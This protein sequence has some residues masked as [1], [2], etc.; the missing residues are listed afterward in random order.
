MQEKHKEMG[1]E[2]IS[3]L[4]VK[5]SLP[6]IIGM[7]VN[8]LYNIVDRI[9]IG[10][11]PEIGPAA[12][13]GVGLVFPIMLVSL[14]FCLLIGLGG[15]TNISISLGKQKK[16]CAEKYLGNATSLAL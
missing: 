9:Y 11:I 13:A 16:H 10:N 6:A 4:L 1:E 2:R 3:K 5:F 14:G 15:A 12:I 7:F 8:A